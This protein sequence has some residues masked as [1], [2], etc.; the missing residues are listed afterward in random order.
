[1]I[2]LQKLV[3]MFA[4]TLAAV[5]VTACGDDPAGVST[6][7][8]GMTVS[9]GCAGTTLGGIQSCTAAGTYG[10]CLCDFDLGGLDAG[11]DGGAPMLDLG[12]D[13]GGTFDAGLDA[14][15]DVGA[16]DA[17]VETCTP[18]SAT[19]SWQPVATPVEP[20]TVGTSGTRLGRLALA[21][22]GSVYVS[23]MELNTVRFTHL[24]VA[25]L[26]GDRWESLGTSVVP[27]TLVPAGEYAIAI[28]RTGEVWAAATVGD[29][30]AS[31][32]AFSWDGS[33]WTQR[34]PLLDGLSADTTTYLPQLAIGPDDAPVLT[35]VEGQTS[36]STPMPRSF[37]RRW[38]GTRWL[39]LG[40]SIE[41]AGAAGMWPTAVIAHVSE[42]GAPTVAFTQAE[43][44]TLANAYIA[45]WDGLDWR[46]VG[47]PI[48]PPDRVYLA[49]PTALTEDARGAL[50]L[51]FNDNR[52]A[53][54]LR[55]DGFDWAPV[56]GDIGADDPADYRQN[57]QSMV[58]EPDGT[59]VI[60][61][62]SSSTL[63]AGT[64][65]IRVRRW[66]GIRWLAL[67]AYP[68]ALP[69]L[70]RDGCGALYAVSEAAVGPTSHVEVYRW[71][72]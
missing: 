40:A 44:P 27:N 12:G 8:P 2:D 66:N 10:A 14:G 65:L 33:V 64:S 19:G 50:H 21:P 72:D 54:I 57:V 25:R 60:A 29:P 3:R 6:C 32:A 70:T 16:P 1:M 53:F 15:I 63:S 38:N 48:R 34:G 35:W 4:A 11:S 36:G 56:A 17:A 58:V 47:S 67:G 39:A 31:V 61:L 28:S 49:Q 20:V 5:C 23:W 18:P 9:C 7:V 46:L 42:S 13:D 45:R 68:A 69:R 41:V 43:T 24:G 26:V 55:F 52:D 30:V 71:V 22:D 51:A 59:P 62:S 37:A